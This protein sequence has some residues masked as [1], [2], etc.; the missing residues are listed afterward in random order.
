MMPNSAYLAM[1]PGVAIMLVSMAFTF[2][3]NGLRDAMD[4][5]QQV[6]IV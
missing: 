2:F 4:S 3:G 5:K 6:A 1:L